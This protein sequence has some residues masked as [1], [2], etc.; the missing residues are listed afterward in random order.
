MA[1]GD[2]VIFDNRRLLHGR[3]GL[4]SDSPRWLRGCYADADG[5]AATLERLDAAAAREAADAR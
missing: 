2:V 1:P 3:R 5:L 4:A